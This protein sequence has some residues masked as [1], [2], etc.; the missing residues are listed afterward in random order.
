M[1]TFT[2]LTEA[3]ALPLG[4]STFY[5]ALPVP[6]DEDPAAHFEFRYRSLGKKSSSYDDDR[7]RTDCSA[8]LKSALIIPSTPSPPPPDESDE[9]DGPDY[10]EYTADQMREMLKDKD[11]QLK[12]NS[13]SKSPGQML[14]SWQS[15]NDSTAKIKRER[16]ETSPRPRKMPR[17]HTG[18]TQL[19][20]D[21][22][23]NVR[24]SATPMVVK[25]KVE[26]I[27]LTDGQTDSLYNQ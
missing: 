17:Q 24:E 26:V 9:P 19:E 22:D 5:E 23:G 25:T 20:V 12:V 1:L 15:Q 2:R 13:F 3:E 16:V 21:D 18:A 7:A 10:S 14:T 6:G 8:A 4:A 11:R 27:E